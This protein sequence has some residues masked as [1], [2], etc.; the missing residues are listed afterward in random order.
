MDELNLKVQN[1]EKQYIEEE[2]EAEKYREGINSKADIYRPGENYNDGEFEL[3]FQNKAYEINYKIR[4]E[5]P[6]LSFDIVSQPLDTMNY[7]LSCYFVVGVQTDETVPQKNCYMIKAYDMYKTRYDSDESDVEDEDDD[8]E[9]LDDEPSLEY[10]TIPITGNVNRVRAMPQNRNIVG[11]WCEDSKVHIY[12]LTQMSQVLRQ[13]NMASSLKSITKSKKAIQTFDFHTTEGFAMDWSKCVEGRLAT[14][15]CNGEI[16]V[17]DMQTNS[18]VHTW[19][20]IYDKPFVGHTGSVEDLQFS[21][22]EDSVFAS[23]SCDRT[24]KF[25]DTR[26]KNR[27]HALSFE[28]SE[29]ADV[30][31][32]SWNPLTSYFIASGDD[33]GVIRIWDVRQCSD[34]SP[35]KPVGQFIYHKNSITSIEWNPIESTLLAASDSDKVTIWD[36]SLERDA[37]QEEI[38]KEI[39]NEIPPQLLFEHMGQVDIKEVHWHPKFQNVLITTS[40]DG[41]SIFKPSNLSEDPEDEEMEQ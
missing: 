7:P 17:M 27:K 26:K 3:T 1:S 37:E 6:A 33:D 24:I 4:N 25:W 21:P 41:Y 38:E 16:N 22:S 13:E 9:N 2:E 12:D 35:M 40:L 10:Q 34:S 15:D 11:F 8:N 29:K 18:G 30:N 5:W 39:G 31:V 14:G 20:R 23:C 32:I 28:A 36:L 19:K